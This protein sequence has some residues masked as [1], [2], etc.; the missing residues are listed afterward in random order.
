[1]REGRRSTLH[2]RL[3]LAQSHARCQP[4]ALNAAFGKSQDSSVPCLRAA[5][6]LVW[7][8]LQPLFDGRNA[9]FGQPSIRCHPVMIP[10]AVL[11]DPIYRTTLSGRLRTASSRIL[12]LQYL[13]PGDAVL[14]AP[15]IGQLGSGLSR[16]RHGIRTA[17]SLLP[18]CCIFADRS[19]QTYHRR[20]LHIISPTPHFSCHLHPS[21]MC[22]TTVDA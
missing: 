5:S 3:A 13:F 7:N 12:P 17:A 21:L 10:R 4:A 15:Q 22:V 14:T 9:G 16:L 2:L 8:K 1:M 6:K 11:R 19:D 18:C 20:T